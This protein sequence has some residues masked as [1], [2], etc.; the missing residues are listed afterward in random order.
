M[1]SAA[2]ADQEDAKATEYYPDEEEKRVVAD[3]KRKYNDKNISKRA[4]EKTW[5]VN[6]AFIR[7]QHYVIF[8]DYTRTFEVPYRVPPHRVRLMVNYM[9]AYV[10]RTKSR[11]TAHKPGYFV[12]PASTDQGDVERARLAGK[13]L[14]SEVDRLKH[15]A[16]FKTAAGWM[17]ECGSGILGLSWNPWAGPELMEDQPAGLDESGQPIVDPETGEPSVTKAPMTDEF[18]RQLHAGENE[19]EAVSP[20]EL[21][22]DPQ[23]TSFDD[24]QWVMRNKI[25]TLNW[26]KENYPD[27]GKFVKTEQVYLNAFY[28][29]RLRQIVGV[30][31]Y[32]TEAQAGESDQDAPKDSTVVHEYWERP[33]EKYPQGRLVVVAGNVLLHD[34]PNPY[35]HGRFPFVKFDEVSVPGRFWGMAMVEQAIPLQ[36]NLNRARSQEVENRT[37]MGR[38]KILVPRT[39]KLRQSAYDAEAGEKLDYN[40]GPRGEKPELIWPQSTTM[41]TQTEIQHTI[42]DM[43]EVLAWHEASRGI[44]PSANIPGIA[45]ERLQGADETSLGDASTSIDVA[46]IALAQMILSNCAQFWSEERMVRAGGEGARL[47]A[48]K[49]RGQDLVGEDPNAEYFDVRVIPHS[50]LLRD[51]AKQREMVKEMIEMGIL[52]PMMHRDV[53]L[54]TLDVSDIDQVFEDDRLDEQWAERENELMEEGTYSVPR[55][56]ENH[57][58]HLKI[59][60]RYR[61]GERYRRLTPAFQQAFDMHA[62][63]HKEMAVQVAQE[64]AIMQTEVAKLVQGPMGEGGE[65]QGAPQGQPEMKQGE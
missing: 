56:F 22:V 24:A 12:R 30:F 15:F 27:K 31:G 18:G 44:L 13:V 63:Q 1:I 29:K 52:D 37:L 41:S 11:L 42:S 16:N 57:A 61:K 50:T 59:L 8:N 65:G 54:K 2:R 55:D 28:E 43:Q 46:M 3:I 25:R 38:P 20:Y 23:A 5:F 48:V 17:L 26:V 49:I 47:E 45:I 4:Y 58:I 7:G 9:L 39:A 21:D 19:L 10:R 33:T 35:K 40:P 14:E 60:D 51:P 62:A 32:T 64:R 34:G 53:I 36:K 6:G